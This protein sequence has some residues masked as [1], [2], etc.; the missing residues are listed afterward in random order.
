MAWAAGQ[1]FSSKFAD[2]HLPLFP[3]A[4]TQMV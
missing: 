2:G 1:P 3:K 4:A